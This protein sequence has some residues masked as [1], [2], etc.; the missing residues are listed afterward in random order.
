VTAPVLRCSQ[1]VKTYTLGDTEVHALRGVDLRVEPGD[2]LAV[3]GPSGSGKSTLL[4]LFGLL[5]RP[6]SGEIEVQ[7][8]PVAGLGDD[9]LAALRNRTIGFVFQTFHL[10]PRA[11]ALDNVALPLL[12][13][14]IPAAQRRERARQC[15]ELVG[16][17]DRTLHRPSELSGGQRQ[18]VAVAR[19]L[20]TDPAL[21]L[22]DEP[23]G[24]LDQ[25]TGREVL[26]LL[27][28]L[29]DQG[30]TILVITHDVDVAARAQRRIHVV[31]G[32]I[33]EI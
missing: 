12:Y 10:L 7:G 24:N 6:T 1:L 5:D 30:R 17:A 8:T 21:V 16:L 28:E 9:E 19:A 29:H 11:T 31:D 23:T 14:G 27:D 33:S 13:S 20:V 15:L 2:Y 26:A 25:A 22:A 32:L 18:R 3:T 4:N